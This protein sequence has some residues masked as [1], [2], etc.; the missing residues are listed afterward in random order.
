M[1]VCVRLLWRERQKKMRV[2][3]GCPVREGDKGQAGF[4]LATFRLRKGIQQEIAASEREVAVRNLYSIPGENYTTDTHTPT[5]EVLRS[6]KSRFL[7]LASRQGH[8]RTLQPLSSPPRL[9][10]RSPGPGPSVSGLSCPK[11]HLP[12][13]FKLTPARDATERAPR[14]S[15]VDPIR[16]DCEGITEV[17]IGAIDC[18][19]SRP[20]ALMH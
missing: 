4:E 12:R 5:S 7:A 15:P 14:L 8:T 16:A 10:C 20:T 19:M 18:E 17:I 3:K 2:P 11:P 13:V 1:C 9:L 6:R